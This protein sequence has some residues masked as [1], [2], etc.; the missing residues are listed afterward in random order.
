MEGGKAPNQQTATQ[1]DKIVPI[2]EEVTEHK[3]GTGGESFSHCQEI[4]HTRV[5]TGYQINGTFPPNSSF[6]PFTPFYYLFILLTCRGWY[7]ILL[8]SFLLSDSFILAFSLPL[9]T[10]ELK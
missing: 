3:V 8:H 7:L 10:S 4:A 9:H 1:K 5:T 2:R 6:S